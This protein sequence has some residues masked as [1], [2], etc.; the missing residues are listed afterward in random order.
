M[1]NNFHKKKCF[2]LYKETKDIGF[3][4]LVFGAVTVCAFF[5]PPKA[6]IVLL[7]LVLI[8]CGL[9]LLKK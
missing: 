2:N 6:W 8:I 7:G 5:L 1:N 4:L 3:V 9:T